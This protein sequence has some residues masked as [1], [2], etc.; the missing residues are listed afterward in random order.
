MSRLTPLTEADLT[1]EQREVLDAIQGGPRGNM[2][3]VGPFGVY[4]RAPGV[5]NAAQALGAAVRYRTSLPENV[6]EVAICTV[7]AFFKAKF[8]FAAHAALAAKAGVDE[9]IVEALRVGRTPEFADEGEALAH[10]VAAALLRDHRVDDALY[11]KA[12]SRFGEQG[13]TELAATIGYYC[14]VSMTLNLFQIP[15]R[16]DMT[17]P[18]PEG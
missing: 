11:D 10:H 8:E 13:M 12:L 16:D 17:D 14:L 3:L 4:V 2:G 15:L 18:F 7:G 6:K 5:G 1:P 9:A